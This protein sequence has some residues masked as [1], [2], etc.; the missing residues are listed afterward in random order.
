[1]RNLRNVMTGYVPAALATGAGLA[2]AAGLYE[3]LKKK[4]KPTNPDN[5]E[6]KPAAALK[7]A[8][9]KAELL[10]AREA[11]N[12][13]PTEAQI[14]AENYAKGVVNI[15]G[16]KI[17]IE[18]PKGSMR[19]GTD[20]SGKEWSQKM[21]WDYGYA[22]GVDAVDGDKLDIFIGP[23]PEKGKIFVVDQ[24]LSG[25]YDESKVMLGFPDEAAAR[26]GYLA[27]YEEGWKGLGHITEMSDA[28][29]KAWCRGGQTTMA[30]SAGSIL[31]G[32]N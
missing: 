17:A 29:F 7:A 19:K 24:L 10:S 30:K 28:K 13:K 4:P 5:P 21:A 20:A 8:A 26:A 32:W 9:F 27:N 11:T 12:D 14:K 22:K 15:R 25:K 1:M 16:L 18:N 6:D 23:D 3:L 2:G 31:L